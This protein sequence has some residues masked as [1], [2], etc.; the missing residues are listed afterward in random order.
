M[1]LLSKVVNVWI[2]AGPVV[3]TLVSVNPGLNLTTLS[4]SFYQDHSLG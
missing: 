2:S 1:L 3:R 4:F